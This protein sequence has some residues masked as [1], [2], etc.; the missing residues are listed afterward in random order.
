MKVFNEADLSVTGSLTQD[1][2]VKRLNEKPAEFADGKSASE[3][4]NYIHY[5]QR[6]RQF[7]R[8]KRTKKTTSNIN[9]IKREN[10][11]TN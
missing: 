1:E 4:L 3:Y 11:S 8:L 7:N 2:L 5:E 6:R 10:R 9:R